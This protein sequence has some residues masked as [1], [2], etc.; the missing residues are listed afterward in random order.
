MSCARHKC[1]EAWALHILCRAR[2][3]RGAGSERP[4]QGMHKCAEAWAVQVYC[5][6]HMVN[7][8]EE[9]LLPPTSSA[10]C[11]K[12]QRQR[13]ELSTGGSH[14]RLGAPWNRQYQSNNVKWAP[15]HLPSA[16]FPLSGHRVLEP[17]VG[18]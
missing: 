7:G 14:Q 18:C 12:Q 9:G 17:A 1:A 10:G 15:T 2:V 16:S 6:R 3:H 5:A 11:K 4:V 13:C 8:G